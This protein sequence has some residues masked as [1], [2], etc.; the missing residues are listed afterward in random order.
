[1][2]LLESPFDPCK[3]ELIMEITGISILLNLS[4]QPIRLHNA[5]MYIDIEFESPMVN[6]AEFNIDGMSIHWSN[7]REGNAVMIGGIGESGSRGMA[8]VTFQRM[9]EFRRINTRQHPCSD[10]SREHCR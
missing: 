5:Y 4:A 1:M 7:P 8:H 6:S 10:E 9:A 3:P 2:V